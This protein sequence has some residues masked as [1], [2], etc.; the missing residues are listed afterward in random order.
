MESD[1]DP[2][3]LLESGPGSCMLAGSDS[4]SDL[5]TGSDSLTERVLLRQGE[6]GQLPCS[7]GLP[8]DF[9]FLVACKTCGGRAAVGKR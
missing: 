7:A 8:T 9:R 4:G 2:G 6:Q 5:L 3:S 1:L